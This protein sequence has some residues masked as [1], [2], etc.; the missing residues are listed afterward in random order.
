MKDTQKAQTVEEM[1]KSYFGIKSLRRH[2]DELSYIDGF[3]DAVQWHQSQSDLV[4]K[5]ISCEERLPDEELAE[6]VLFYNSGYKLCFIGMLY[7]RAE[8]TFWDQSA[9]THTKVTHWQPLP[10]PPQI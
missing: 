8:M 2:N 10:Q 5:W 9:D 6:D 1:A 7:D 3:K 4:S